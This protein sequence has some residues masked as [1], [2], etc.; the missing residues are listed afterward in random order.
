MWNTLKMHARL[1][2][3]YYSSL[4]NFITQHQSQRILP[5]NLYPHYPFSIHLKCM[6][7]AVCNVIKNFCAYMWFTDYSFNPFAIVGTGAHSMTGQ[8]KSVDE[9]M[10]VHLHNLFQYA[11]SDQC[12]HNTCIHVHTG[13][14]PII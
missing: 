3:Y 2:H 10:H 4:I 11:R 1:S 6:V 14:N 7:C 9:S 13:R 8:H 12:D 5:T